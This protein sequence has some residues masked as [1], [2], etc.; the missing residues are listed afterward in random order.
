M[1]YL[2]VLSCMIFHP[3]LSFT[4]SHHHPITFCIYFLSMVSDIPRLESTTSTIVHNRVQIMFINQSIN[5]YDACQYLHYN[6]VM[7][8]TWSD[9]TDVGY[10]YDGSLHEVSFQE[11]AV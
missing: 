6:S 11:Q 3:Y 5:Q 7:T 4:R 10:R 2:F 1:M 8:E 9:M